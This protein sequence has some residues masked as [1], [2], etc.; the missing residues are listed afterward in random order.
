MHF[1]TLTGLQQIPFIDLPYQLPGWF[2]WLILAGLLL[3]GTLKCRRFSTPLQGRWLVIFALLLASTPLATFFLNVPMSPG[4]VLPLPNLPLESTQPVVILLFALP[5]VIAAGVLGP[6]PAVLVGLTSSLLLAFFWTHTFFT[7]IEVG[8]LALLYSIAVRQTYRTNFFKLLRHPFGAAVFLAVVTVP[9]FLF[10]AFFKIPGTLAERLDFTFTQNWIKILSRGIELMIAGGLAEIMVLIPNPFWMK[11][12]ELVPSPAEASLKTR[13]LTVTLPMILSLV[14]V[15]TLGDWIVAG[16]AARKML[17]DRLTSS[18]RIAS[19]SLPYF[20]ESGQSLILDLAKPE[21]VSLPYMQLMN[22]LEAGIHAVPY[23]KQLFVMNTDK[24]LLAGYPMPDF[25]LT[26]PLDNQEKLALDFALKGVLIQTYTVLPNTSGESAQVSFI[27]ALIDDHG[28]TRGVILGRTD[29]NSNPFTQ[30]ALAALEEIS[31]D[32]GEGYILDESQNI[33]YR[34]QQST[35]LIQEEKYVSRI[36]EEAVFFEDVSATGTRQ[37]IYYQPVVGKPWSVV[38]SIPARVAQEMALNIA[39]PLLVILIVFAMLAYALIQISLGQLTRKLQRLEASAS[40]ISS[41]HLATPVAI[42]GVDEIGRLGES[43]DQMREGLRARLEELDKLLKISKGVAAH[44]EVEDAIQPI[45][46]AALGEEGVSARSVL[47]EA[48]RGDV[49]GGGFISFGAGPKADLYS[50]LDAQIFKLMYSQSV[51]AISNTYRVRR[52][53]TAPN[54]PRPSALIALA[55]YHENTY[56]GTIW[57]G[58][59]HPKTFSEEEVRFLS[60]IASETA[61]AAANARLYASA[62]IGRRRMEAVLSSTPEPVLV[63]DDND[64]LL[65]LNPA[66]LHVQG[67]VSSALPGARIQDILSNG[68]LLN[69]LTGPLEERIVTREVSMSNSRVYH[70]LVAPVLGEDRQV[71]K[72]C[73]LRDITHYKQLDTLKSEFVDTVSHDLRAPITLV[74]GYN[75]MLNMVGELNEQQKNYVEKIKAG[76]ESMRTL[77]TNLLD[78]GRID[79]GIGLNLEETQPEVIVSTVLQQLQPNANQ[80]SIQLSFEPRPEGMRTSIIAD[81]TL[82]RQALLNIVDNAIKFTKVNGQVR[83]RLQQN[84]D[85]VLFEVHDTGIGIAPIDLPNVFDKFY[86]SK[87]RE[88]MDQRGTGLGLA[89]VK[90]ITE[91]HNGEVWAKSQLGKGSTFYMQIPVRYQ[92]PSKT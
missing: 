20:L 45:L 38:V 70:A 47:I 32:G 9:I 64:R 82:L 10:S 30:P 49:Q 73:V 35:S 76:L 1:N 28:N 3:W 55:L 66:A 71:G 43:F 5:W 58:Y 81:E 84:G 12:Q 86:R 77:V 41:G 24:E 62:E 50:H 39:I 57:V 25:S 63:F 23:F 40:L 88:G 92:E 54:Q 29:L 56:Y 36:P 16:Q 90:S 87:R 85:K 79:A 91:R 4:G 2:G 44:L 65:L 26:Q 18:A 69:L 67:L 13:F 80:R 17:E 46:N 33:L 6:L 31:R 89:I 15:L 7:P 22:R 11:P 59:D 8:V 60:T 34:A 72:V 83:V 19:E 14:L 48:V 78:L 21:L 75:S 53:I 61:M 52:I 37:F 42:K 68:D 51:I 74:S 27:A